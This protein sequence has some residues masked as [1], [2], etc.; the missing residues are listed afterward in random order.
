MEHSFSEPLS[1]RSLCVAMLK[2]WFPLECRL[3]S[4]VRVCIDIE[5][6][7]GTVVHYISLFKLCVRYV[8]DPRCAHGL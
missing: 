3:F 7:S 5:Y 6:Q 1:F 4:I 2:N 8:Y